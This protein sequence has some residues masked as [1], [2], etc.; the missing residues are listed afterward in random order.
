MACST[1]KPH[2]IYHLPLPHFLLTTNLGRA[3]K[4][5]THLLHFRVTG[6]YLSKAKMQKLSLSSKAGGAV[7]MITVPT[8]GYR[9]RFSCPVNSSFLTLKEH[10]EI[11]MK[12]YEALDA[13]G[14]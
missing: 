4:I 3:D 11:K 9:E 13:L 2:C 8:R 7:F 6:V 5:I 14:R 12:L 1:D 10:N